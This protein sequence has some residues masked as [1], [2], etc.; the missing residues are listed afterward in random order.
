ML[1]I[2]SKENT[3]W[4][5]TLD[6]LLNQFMATVKFVRKEAGRFREETLAIGPAS[7]K[8]RIGSIVSGAI[9]RCPLQRHSA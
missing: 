1:T 7:G 6:Q 4:T 3:F 8:W 2:R 5:G 9:G